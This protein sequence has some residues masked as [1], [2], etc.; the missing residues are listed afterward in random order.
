M[1]LPVLALVIALLSF[2]PAFA[3]DEADWRNAEKKENLAHGFWMTDKGRSKVKV[4][5]CDEAQGLCSEIVWLREPNNS[6]G[7]PLTDGRNQNPRLR[8]RPIMGL[9]I[10]EGLKQIGRYEWEGEVYNPEDGKTYKR[11][12]GPGE[13]RHAAP[14]G[15][16]AYGMAVPL[17]ILDPHRIRAARAC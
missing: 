11:Q 10:L 5:P 2:G 7:V 3:A 9:K 15:V 13:A 6:R 1:Q 12:S 17:Q 16:H 8:K 4:A 14:E